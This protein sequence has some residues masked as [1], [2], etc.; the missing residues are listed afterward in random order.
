[1]AEKRARSEPFIEN[2]DLFPSDDRKKRASPEGDARRRKGQRRRRNSVFQY[3]AILFMAAFALLLITFLMERRQSQQQIDDLRQS[4]SAYQ[5]LQG[6]MEENETLQTRVD[7]LER[8]LEQ[9]KEAANSFEVSL[10]GVTD[11]LS[12]TENVL[13]WTSRAMDYFWQINEAYVRGRYAL[14]R[15]LIAKIESPETDPA[16]GPLMEYLPKESAT[17]TDRFSPYERYQEIRGLVIR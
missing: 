9:Q 16:A 17:G 8:E 15:E 12:H 13:A 5:T 14:C 3:I 2:A 6:L 10:D 1:M 11:T 7:E 4:A